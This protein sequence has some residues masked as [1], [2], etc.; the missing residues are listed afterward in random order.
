MSLVVLLAGVVIWV[1]TVVLIL[2]DVPGGILVTG[3]PYSIARHPLYTGVALL[4]LR[5][6]RRVFLLNTWLGGVALVL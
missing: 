4:A 6:A 3:G 5:L 2:R 1:W